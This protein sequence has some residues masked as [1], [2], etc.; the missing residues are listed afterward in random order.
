MSSGNSQSSE[1]EYNNI[2]KIVYK[3]GEFSGTG[4]PLE[5]NQKSYIVTSPLHFCLGSRA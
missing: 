1:F 4:F 5:E 2:I 3:K